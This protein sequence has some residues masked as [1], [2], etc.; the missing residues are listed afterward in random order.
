MERANATHEILDI[1]DTHGIE[2]D[3]IGTKP[4]MFI[5]AGPSHIVLESAKDRILQRAKDCGLRIIDPSVI[6]DEL[7]E[8]PHD[9]VY[10]WSEDDGRRRSF[11]LDASAGVR[12]E[13]EIGVNG[14]VFG[15]VYRMN[16]NRPDVV[17]NV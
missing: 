15:S 2:V 7:V 11:V 12:D 13:F 4:H 3:P 6:S 16:P 5:L 1:S 10:Y 9:A 17:L 8:E 14:E